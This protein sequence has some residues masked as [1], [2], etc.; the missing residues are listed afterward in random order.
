MGSTW[1]GLLDEFIRVWDFG[2]YRDDPARDRAR[3][4][5]FEYTI[6]TI[7]EKLRD[8]EDSHPQ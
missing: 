5:S 6:Q 2:D 3:M 7:L 1:Q 8:A 4:D